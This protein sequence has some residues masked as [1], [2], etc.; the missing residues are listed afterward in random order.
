MLML[1]E[2]EWELIFLKVKSS[3]M[4]KN[5]DIKSLSRGDR[6]KYKEQ[7]PKEYSLYITTTKSNAGKTGGIAKSKSN[8][9]R[10]IK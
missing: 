2:Q 10:N 9:L 8:Y 7:Y 4:K 5:I 3:N 1:E 6:K